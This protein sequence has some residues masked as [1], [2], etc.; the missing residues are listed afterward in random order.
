MLH[1]VCIT[2]KISRSRTMQKGWK[3][4][5][6]GILSCWSEQRRVGVVEMHRYNV[7]S[8]LCCETEVEEDPDGS[9]HEC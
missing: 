5:S 3:V 6:H 2:P 4:E 1:N 7:C 9:G 8:V